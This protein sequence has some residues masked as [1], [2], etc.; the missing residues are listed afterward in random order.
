M[1]SSRS[2]PYTWDAPSVRRRRLGAV[3]TRRGRPGG[4]RRRRASAA[5]AGVNPFGSERSRPDLQRRVLLPTNQWISP[6]GTRIEDQH[7]RIVVEHAQPRRPVHGGADLERLHRLPDDHRPE[8]RQD[9]P[10]RRRLPRHAR[11]RG[12]RTGR[13][14]RR[15][16]SVL[17]ARRQD[18]LGAA[19]GRHRQ[20]HGRSGNRHGVRKG[21]H[22]RCRRPPT[23]PLRNTPPKRPAPPA[24]RCPRA[25]RSRPTAP[26]STWPSTA[27]NTLGVI[28]TATNEA[29]PQIP[30]GNAPRQVVLDGNTAYVSN[31]G[32]RPG[33]AGRIH[34][35]LRRDPDRLQPGHRRRDTGTVSVVNLTTGNRGTGDPGRPA[36][37]RRSTR[38]AGAV[39]RQLQRRQHL[40]DRH[41]RP[42]RWR[43]RS[44]STRCPGATV[45]SYA[46]RD[47]DARPRTTSWSA[48]AAT[49]RSPSTSTRS[50][51]H[52]R[53][54]QT[55]QVRGSAADRLVPGPGAARSG[56]RAGEIVVTNDNGIGDRG[57]QSTICKGPET[58]PAPECANGLQHLRR[59]RHRHHV[60][61]AD[62]R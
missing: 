31:E 29:R 49:T 61:D 36:S 9:R 41:R 50:H 37:R 59:H 2:D 23:A 54:N 58:S 27:S 60:Q 56:A 15:R 7:G 62:R 52:G 45:G 32:G 21:H 4:R 22:P 40:G 39:R 46:E 30:V 42:T 35:P 12:R 16:R 51:R 19:D 48:S 1:A 24:K 5:L 6:L 13:R 10:G 11:P 28:N 47:H 33:Q 34:Q 18:A 14:G 3:A 38:T 17:L 53:A 8:D 44:T 55:A 20:V 26:S 57:P 43:R 25:W